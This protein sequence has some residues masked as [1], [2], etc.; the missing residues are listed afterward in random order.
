M[1]L[2]RDG[3]TG[4]I[5]QFRLL[6]S[7]GNLTEYIDL[8]YHVVFVEGEEKEVWSYDANGNGVFG[9]LI[10]EFRHLKLVKP[11]GNNLHGEVVDVDGDPRYF[12]PDFGQGHVYKYSIDL[13][14]S[15]LG[16]FA[17]SSFYIGGRIL[18]ARADWRDEEDNHYDPR[19]RGAQQVE[20]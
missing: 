4:I 19:R 20:R 18:K 10:S 1:N 16:G 3:T 11:K 13:T 8:D 7:N 15:P 2:S 17:Y 5:Q 9:E 6:T 12:G 14:L